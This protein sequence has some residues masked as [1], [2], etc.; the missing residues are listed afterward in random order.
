MALYFT[1]ALG[2]KVVLNIGKMSLVEFSRA[3]PLR[4]G[5]GV[6]AFWNVNLATPISGLSPPTILGAMM[7]IRSEPVSYTLFVFDASDQTN[8]KPLDDP[9]GEGVNVMATAN[10]KT[11]IAGRT[12]TYAVKGIYS[13]KSGLD[14]RNLD[15]LL[16]PSAARNLTFKKGSWYVGL[17]GQQYI[18]QD[19]SNPTR[20][21]GL[22]G[23][24]TAADGNPNTLQWSGYL[25]LGGS[26][27][28]PGRPT[29]R[30]GVAV[31]R[32]GASRDLKRELAAVFKLDDEA[33]A[34]AFYN[35]AVTPW[36]RITADIQ[37]VDPA[38]GAFPHDV[39]AGVGTSVKF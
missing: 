26:S 13:T 20:G 10:W 25:G 23:E 12:G 5:G 1:Q 4:G 27:L 18:F 11:S 29:D 36:L 39:F 24:I 32:Y 7:Q 16:L 9:F 6:D 21:W 8:R 35:V 28:I 15:Q 17:S 3:T 30:F 2:D 34:E 37:Y 31:F 33:G 22:F 38:S 14:F 19:R